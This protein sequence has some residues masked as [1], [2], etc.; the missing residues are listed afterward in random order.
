M[1]NIIA[2]I[3]DIKSCDSLNIV[4]FSYHS[5][6]LSM[7]SLELSEHI[8]IGTKVK[9]TIKSTHISIAKDLKGSISFENKLSTKITNI[10]NGELLSSIT[11]EY[12]DT[13]LEV[14]VTKE[15]IKNMDL[16]VNDDIIAFVQMSELSISEI[17]DD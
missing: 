11:L 1:S 6:I 2:T 8:K 3:K 10:E 12:F 7:M 14:I 16:K 13:F 9:L 5:D 15:T 17:I 4:Q